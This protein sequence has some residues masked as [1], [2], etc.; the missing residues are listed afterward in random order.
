M[1]LSLLKLSLLRLHIPLTLVNSIIN[2]FTNRKNQIILHNYYSEKYD[3]IQSI[4]QGEVISSLLWNCYY[5]PIFA[6]INDTPD[7]KLT[8]TVNKIVDI[9]NTSTDRPF[10]F[11]AAVVGYLDDTSWFATSKEK[12]ETN[13]RN[14]ELFLST[15][16]HNHKPRQIRILTNDR[17]Y[18]NKTITLDIAENKSISVKTAACS[19]SKRILGIYTNAKTKTNCPLIRWY[20]TH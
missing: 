1:N 12:L 4:D 3:V 2:L 5:D 17:K 19:Q 8:I 20:T 18:C 6:R 9:H 11:D 15:K 10:I 14:Y 13:L 7:N 16:Q